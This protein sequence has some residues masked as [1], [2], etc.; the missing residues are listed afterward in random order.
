MEID[1][2]VADLAG[3]R[4]MR[5]EARRLHDVEGRELERARLATA[6][7]ELHDDARAAGLRRDHGVAVHLAWTFQARRHDLVVDAIAHVRRAARSAAAPVRTHAE[8]DALVA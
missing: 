3:R 4:T 6:G 5:D 1:L 2:D 8:R 7:D